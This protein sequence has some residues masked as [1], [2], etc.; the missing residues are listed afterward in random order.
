MRRARGAEAGERVGGAEA[1]A[2]V[3]GVEGGREQRLD[4]DAALGERSEGVGGGTLD[5]LRGVAEARDEGLELGGI[6]AGAVGDLGDRRAALVER[7]RAEALGQGHRGPASRCRRAC[8][9]GRCRGG[10]AAGPRVPRPTAASTAARS[11]AQPRRA[12]SSA[13]IVSSAA[14][15]SPEMHASRMRPS[16]RWR[17]A[18]RARRASSPPRRG[19]RGRARGGACRA[20]P[21][22]WRSRRARDARRL[23]R[24]RA[25]APPARR[26]ALRVAARHPVGDAPP[27]DGTAPALCRDRRRVRRLEHRR[28]HHPARI[29]SVEEAWQR[30]RIAAHSPGSP[31]RGPRPSASPRTRRRRAAADPP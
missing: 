5:G 8:R 15:R 16:A 26:R 12:S 21:S 22:P 27:G 20:M 30:A 24:R 14:M 6:Y 19:G 23:V 3:G 18:R 1:E 13:G 2:R 9:R 17:R 11:A 4:G 7:L 29:G 31:R 10:T 28:P 25:C